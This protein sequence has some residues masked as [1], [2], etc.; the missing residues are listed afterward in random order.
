MA[1]VF[2]ITH[3]EV[4][5][6]PTAPI[7]RWSLSESGRQ[8]MALFLRREPVSGLSDL[9]SSTETKSIEAAAMLAAH[10]GLHRVE[11]AALGEN[12]R[13]ATGYLPRPVFERA[14]DEFFAKPEQSH[15]GWERACDAQQRIIA[16]VD[17]AVRQARGGQ[18]AIV[19]HGAVG[20]LYKCHLKQ[21]AITR[22]EDQP[23]QGNFYCFESETRTLLHD[24]MPLAEEG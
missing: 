23:S 2:F 7:T 5:I 13:S 9:Y 16:A 3:P 4:L 24:W 19:S 12:D 10:C 18:I 20:A 8:Q 17:L 6:D 15:R 11:L 22:A 14:A 21:I 1:R